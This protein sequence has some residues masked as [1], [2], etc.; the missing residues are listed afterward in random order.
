MLIAS[1]CYHWPTIRSPWYIALVGKI[2]Q[3]STT[4][5]DQLR[6]VLLVPNPGGVGVGPVGEETGTFDCDSV[7]STGW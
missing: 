2:D 7:A 1:L 3:Q 6:P 5:C 4:V